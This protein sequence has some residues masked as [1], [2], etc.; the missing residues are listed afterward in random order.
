MD[1]CSLAALVTGA[2]WLCRLAEGDGPCPSAG[3][4]LAGRMVRAHH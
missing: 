2:F 1:S 4:V 3:V